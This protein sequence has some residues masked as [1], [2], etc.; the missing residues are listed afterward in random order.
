MLV[1]DAL[2]DEGAEV[3]GPAASVDDALRL[4]DEAQVDGALDAAVLDLN[5]DGSSALPVADRLCALGVPFLF[6]TGYGLDCAREP[7]GAVP[8]LAK[9]YDPRQVVAGVRHLCPLPKAA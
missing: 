5:L 8:V 4:I 3:V 1:E 7:H 9:P 6:A 2:V